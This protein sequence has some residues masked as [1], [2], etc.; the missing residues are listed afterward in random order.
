MRLRCWSIK[1]GFGEKVEEVDEILNTVA[2]AIDVRNP[3]T[4]FVFNGN[5]L[6][7]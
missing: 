7:L 4:T 1:Y 5:G 2:K 3:F 6:L